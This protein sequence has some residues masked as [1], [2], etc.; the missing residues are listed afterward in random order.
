MKEELSKVIQTDSATDIDRQAL[1]D[2][3]Q[4][5][6]NCRQAQSYKIKEV[7]ELN[8][9]HEDLLRALKASREQRISRIE[10]SQKSF[11]EL[12]KNIYDEEFK[13]REGRLSSLA[14]LASQKELERLSQTHQYMDGQV[15]QPILSNETV[16]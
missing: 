9:E 15:D 6:T 4:S 16:I 2:V 1:A 14:K 3:E 12:I 13:E 10:N 5:I 11:M 8:K 7:R